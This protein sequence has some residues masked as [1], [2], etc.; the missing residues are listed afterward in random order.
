MTDTKS[1]VC[2]GE[3]LWDI[4]PSGAVPGG[5]PMNV[6][7]HLQKLGLTPGIITRVGIDEK[8]KQLIDLLTGNGISTDHIQLDMMCLQVL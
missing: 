2:F 6:A 1:I 8:G 7:Y 3:I 4:L 5:A